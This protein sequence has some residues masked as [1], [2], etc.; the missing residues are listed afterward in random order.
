MTYTMDSNPNIV[1][2]FGDQK[3]AEKALEALEHSGFPGEQFSLALQTPPVTETKAGKNA[4]KGAIAG[5]LCGAMI[6]FILSYAKTNFAETVTSD[7][8][9]RNLVG[10]VL[11]GSLIGAAAFGLM[12]AMTGVNVV[13]ESDEISA[14]TPSF[15]VF[16]KDLQPEE[17]AKA[18]K[19]LMEHGSQI[20]E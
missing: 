15:L 19:I 13:K 16:A 6:G 11:I 9:I 1:G 7:S 10:L 14:L 12:E 2:A 20:Q 4:G 17:V 8:P 3:I 18:K 5:A